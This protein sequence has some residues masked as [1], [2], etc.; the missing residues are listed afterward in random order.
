MRLRVVVTAHGGAGDG[1]AGIAQKQVFVHDDP[2]LVAG[3]PRRVDGASS[4]QPAFANLDGRPGD[5]LIVATDAGV[6]HAYDA[7]GK[8]IK[9]WPVRTPDA[10]WW[11]TNSKTARAEHIDEPGAAITTGAPVVADL[12]GDGKIEVVV[13]DTDGNV[14]AWSAG[15]AARRGFKPINVD[16]R[17]QSGAH[18]DP[19]VRSRRHGDPGSVQPDE[20]RLRERA[21]RGRPRRRRQARDRRCRARPPR[22]RVARRRHAGRRLPGAR[23][24]PGQ[25]RARSIPCRTA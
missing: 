21:R 9:G 5:E 17:V 14:W 24:R 25:G 16:G 10:P 11:P 19:D 13:S 20:A 8:D 4:A 22:V 7:R 2:D 1:L 15:G 3:F 23:G 6:V 12:D 18:V